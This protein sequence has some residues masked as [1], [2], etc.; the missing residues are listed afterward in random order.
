MLL[1]RDRVPANGILAVG[2]VDLRHG[3]TDQA[4]ATV[5]RLDDHRSTTRLFP[6]ACSDRAALPIVV[7]FEQQSADQARD[8]LLVGEDVEHIRTPLDLAA[9]A[10]ERINR[11]D[12]WSMILGEGHEG[13]YVG[14]CLVHATSRAV[15]RRA[16]W[17]KVF[18][19]YLAP[20]RGYCCLSIFNR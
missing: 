9:E 14:L 6:G 13:K 20:S 11:V 17:G 4:V 10:L 7:M 2:P 16:T 19:V 3:R 8:R 12:F 5:G 15:T 18:V 1:Q